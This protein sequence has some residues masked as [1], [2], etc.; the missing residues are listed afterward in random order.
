MKLS[1]AG[2]GRIA[3]PANHTR[4]SQVTAVF[5][6]R[7]LSVA[8]AHTQL[9]PYAIDKRLAACR[10]AFRRKGLTLVMLRSQRSLA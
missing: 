4:L 8:S 1:K 7:R 6:D 2:F 5:S 9:H 10:Q 3:R